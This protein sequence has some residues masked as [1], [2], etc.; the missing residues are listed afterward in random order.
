MFITCLL[1]K[2][3]FTFTL[4]KNWSGQN[5]SSRTN[6]AGPVIDIRLYV[7][8]VITTIVLQLAEAHDCPFYETSA[9]TGHNVE[10]VNTS[11]Y[12][13]QPSGFVFLQCSCVQINRFI[14]YML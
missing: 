4:R 8:D 6:S 5:R 7:V 12:G 10:K 11:L 13:T 9:K 3:T 2:W 1:Q 14:L